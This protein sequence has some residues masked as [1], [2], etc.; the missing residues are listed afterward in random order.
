MAKNAMALAIL[1]SLALLA[2]ACDRRTGGHRRGGGSPSTEHLLLTEISVEDTS[3]EYFEIYNPTSQTI[4]LTNYYV[5]DGTDT[6]ASPT[7]EYWKITNPATIAD[8][9]SGAIYD[10]L[11]RFP[12]GATI[13]PGE[14]QV[15][16]PDSANFLGNVNLWSPP[17]G[18]N[19]T[20]ELTQD[21][22][23]DGV[24]DMLPAISSPVSIGSSDGLTNTS[25]VLVI[26][27]WD[28][29]ST[30][31]EDVDYFVWRSP[32]TGN[33]VRTDKTGVS[34][35]VAD[36]PVAQQSFGWG[37][38]GSGYSIRRVNYLEGAE[39]NTGGNGITGH[40][41]T[42]EDVMTTFDDRALVS[43]FAW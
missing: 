26:F 33:D 2:A 21:G 4:D 31:V 40:D 13:A 11:V 29:A 43:P 28:G 1:L 9:W 32:S 41:E 10:F 16:A 6:G 8:A 22:A 35:Y 7:K 38:H 5:T 24:P 3:T 18:R 27:Y 42:S 37:D 20:Y 23:G 17:P 36:T 34:G 12:A 30:T 14:Y 39:R 19:P 15:V 25:E